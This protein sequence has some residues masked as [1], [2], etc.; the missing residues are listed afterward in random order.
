MGTLLEEIS[1]QSIVEEEYV[2][3]EPFDHKIKH[4]NTY[5]EQYIESFV[6]NEK[7]RLFYRF[8]KRN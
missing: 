1:E 4:S 7:K 8:V 2:V 5:Y 3:G 6:P